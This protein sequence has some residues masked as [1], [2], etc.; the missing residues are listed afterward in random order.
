MRGIVETFKSKLAGEGLWAAMHLLNERVP[1]RFTAVFAFNGDLLRNICLVD[2][3][4][5]D[6]F[7]CPDQPITDSYCIYIHRSGES[8]SLTE[9]TLD[10]RVKGHPKQHS[11]QCYYGIPLYGQNEK[12]LGTVCHFDSA[13]VHVTDDIVAA[14]DDLAPLIAGAAW[15]A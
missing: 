11:F 6:I 7:N 4:N 5:P 2:K 9:A 3:N 10:E 1:Y 15:P 14:L 13:P 8:F 12:L